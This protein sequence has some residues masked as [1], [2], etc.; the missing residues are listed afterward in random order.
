MLLIEHLENLFFLFQVHKGPF[1]EVFEV[2]RS[3][4]SNF[5]D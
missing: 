3:Q 2:L 4:N 5:V 1:M